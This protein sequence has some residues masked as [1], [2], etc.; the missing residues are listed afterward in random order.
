MV[1]K[2]RIKFF[3]IDV[4]KILSNEKTNNTKTKIWKIEMPFDGRHM[5]GLV[6]SSIWI[7][8]TYIYTMNI[9][10]R[11]ISFANNLLSFKFLNTFQY[12]LLYFSNWMHFKNNY[13]FLILSH[14]SSITPFRV[15]QRIILI[16]YDWLT[17]LKWI[18]INFWKH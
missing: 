2:N 6:M 3:I 16:I 18:N 14:F 1:I 10:Y 17:E 12:N 5:T 4:R 9:K 7:T 11:S 8:I 15:I 13:R